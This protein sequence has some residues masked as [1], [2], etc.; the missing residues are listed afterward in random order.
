MA[1][2]NFIVQN[3]ISLGGTS[4]ATITAD[5][6]TGAVAIAPAAT[7]ANPNPTATVFTTSGTVTTVATSGGVANV[8]NIATASNT[9]TV[10]T[11]LTTFGNVTMANIFVNGSVGTSGQFL[12]ANGS[13]LAWQTVSTSSISNGTSNVT[14]NSNNI[15]FGVS[16]ANVATFTPSTLSATY[17]GNL[18]MNGSIIPSANITYALG[19]STRQWKDIFVGPG[20]LYVNGKQVITDNSGTITFSTS[21]GQNL[22]L[23]TI[24]GGVLQLSGNTDGGGGYVSVQ[25]TMQIASAAQIT[26]SDGNA[27]K[28][29]NQIGVDS[30]TTKTNNTN[31]SL[32][33][34]GTG[35]ITINNQVTGGGTVTFSDATASTTTTTGAV[36]VNGGVGVGGDLRVSGNVYSYGLL[37]VQSSQLSVNAPLVYLAATPYPYSYDIGMYSH[38][39]GGAANAYQHTGFVRSQANGY[40]GLFANVPSE[41]TTTVNW[42]DPQ[43]MWDAIKTG[44]HIIANTTASTT[45]TTGALRVAGGAGIAG[46]LN[47]GANVTV[48]G[49]I[50]P[51]ANVTYNL[52]SPTARWKDLFLSGSTIDLGGT[53]MS[54]PAGGGFSVATGS[55][56]ANA[57][58]A[59]T[60]SS[61]G[62]LIVPNG[63]AG[64]S[65][66]VFT[67]GWIVPT[68]NTTQNLGTT[69]NWWG[70]LYGVST[71][72]RYADLA[73][74]YQADR[75]YAPGTVLMFGGDQEVT[76]ADTDT[77]RVAGVVSTNPAHLMNGGLSG[78]NVV[79]LALQGR[80]PCN[81]IGPVTKGDLMVSAGHGYA[82]VNN[83][84]GVGQ[85]IGKA[86]V[87][88][89]GA[90]GQIEIVVGRV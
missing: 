69:S 26:S 19:S 63:G 53:T 16:G 60:S 82:K 15:T 73:E 67:G 12:S 38:F 55:I 70:T 40:W 41:P 5:P 65:G 88:F 56:Y 49:A 85:V 6:T 14:V 17:G 28:F 77:T 4:G 87:N 79:P 83:A 39:V 52:G 36:V 80:V 7:A 75:A 57:S 58:I 81:V 50:L 72:A 24:G 68:G 51:S 76:A 37:A 13:G 46:Q 34:Q 44:D 48:T 84:A 11:G 27:I 29:G 3:G 18:I 25:S 89:S 71:Q 33:A 43:L 78:V 30:I 59:S 62:A 21:S 9:A 31:L 2:A 8:A 32:A 54:A 45:T 10:G 86:L 90:K 64:I 20:S 66:N 47:V 35:K 74:N 23:S 1:N 61:T 42:N 22:Q